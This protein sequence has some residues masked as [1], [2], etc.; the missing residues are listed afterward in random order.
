[1]GAVDNERMIVNSDR[2]LWCAAAL[3]LMIILQPSDAVEEAVVGSP[4]VPAMFVFGDSLVDVGNNNFLR[5]FAK[6][7]YY[8]YGIDFSGGPTG[9]FT[10]GR[11]M[12]DLL[13]N[14]LGLPYVPAFA[15]PST[16]GAKILGGVNYA[17]A[18]GGILDETGQ[19]YGER[20][21]LSQQ[22][23]NFEST[24]NQLTTLLGG[25]LTQYLAKSIA[26]LVF[27]SND[28][29]NNYLLPSL[30]PS[31]YTYNPQDY[32]NL[33]LNRYAR[34]IIALYSVGLR[35]FMLA[36]IGPLGCIPNQRAS[37]QA[38]PG[39]C[40]DNVNQMLGPFNEGLRLMV[41][42]FNA[43]HTGATYV[44]GNVYGAIGDMLNTPATYG[45]NVIDSACCGLGR[46]QGRITCLP[47]NVP[48]SNRNQ[49]LFWDAFH[50]TEAAN[51]ILAW[52]AFNGSPVDCYPI[53]VQQLAL[54]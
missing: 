15:D 30:Y 42:Q 19:H 28:Y 10:N 44:Y 22:V 13:G 27:G 50:P 41:N 38:P 16:T 48:C 9:R 49:Y 23:L 6:S 21:T 3:V 34:Q 5:S 20:F 45:F 14:L 54:I 40:L 1:M 35:K 52:R 7:N 8:P 25:N 12:V 2:L 37:G 18:A 17:S 47:F 4:L 51:A 33:L 24:V 11:N 29:I 43:N 53:N 36:G 31:S 39:R 26:V 32:A 46:N